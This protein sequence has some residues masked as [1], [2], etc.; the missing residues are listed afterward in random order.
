MMPR[1]KV[2]D[3][4]LI[5]CQRKPNWSRGQDHSKID[6]TPTSSC[7]FS[8]IVFWTKS[9]QWQSFRESG[10]AHGMCLHAILD[11][12]SAEYE[13]SQFRLHRCSQIVGFLILHQA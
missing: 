1:V 4:Y 6:T 9:Q 12:S 2:E 11:F 7:L 8:I 3:L 5:Y 10:E 13:N